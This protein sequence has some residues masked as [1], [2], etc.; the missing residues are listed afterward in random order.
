MEIK[1]QV[2]FDI[3][4]DFSDD[5]II[6]AQCSGGWDVEEIH[7]DKQGAKQLIEILKEFVGEN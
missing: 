1:Q 5:D 4:I 3:G 6:L 7:I 2:H